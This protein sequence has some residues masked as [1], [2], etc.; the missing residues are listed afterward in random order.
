[1][2]LNF[3]KRQKIGFYCMN[4]D[5]PIPMAVAEGTSLFYACPRYFLMDKDHP[6]GHS[7]GEPACFNRLSFQD[8][9]EIVKTFSEIIEDDIDSD[10]TADY[11]G[12][13]FKYKGINVTVIEYS[14]NPETSGREED[15]PPVKLG[16]LNPAA[17]RR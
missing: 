10:V 5:E 13:P 9:A 2:I 4:H 11:T 16:I 17:M 8:A 6:D 12:M 7:V 1:M 3:W 15:D 14:E